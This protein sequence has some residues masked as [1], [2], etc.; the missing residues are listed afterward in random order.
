MLGRFRTTL[1]GLSAALITTSCM[2]KNVA[3]Q[4]EYYT[5]EQVGLCNGLDGK[6]TW[7][8]HKGSVYDI[9]EFIAVHP[10]GQQFIERAAG[11]DVGA[12]WNVWQK[13]YRSPKVIEVLEANRI[14]ALLVKESSSD[15]AATVAQEHPYD[16]EPVRNR[17]VHKVQ[18]EYPFTT[19]TNLLPLSQSY[20][21]PADTLYVRNH[22]PVPYHLTAEEHMLQL[23]D[24]GDEQN[25][26]KGA[27]MRIRMVDLFKK[28][29]NVTITAVMQCAGNRTAEDILASGVAGNGF[30]GTPHEDIGNGMMGNGRWTG[31]RLADVLEDYFPVQCRQQR[32]LG[33]C[34]SSNT[35]GAINADEDAERDLDRWHV[36]FLGA[37]E[38]ESSTP[39]SHVLAA[40]SD[41][42]LVTDMNDGPLSGDHGYPLRVLLPGLAGARSVKWLEEIVLSRAPSD[43]PWN[44]YYYR[45]TKGNHIQSLPLQSVILSPGKGD[46]VTANVPVEGEDLPAAGEQWVDVKGVAYSGGSGRAIRSVQVS[47]DQGKTWQTAVLHTEELQPDDS[48]AFYGWVRYSAKVKIPAPVTNSNSVVEVEPTI[49]LWC[50]AE[51][52]NGEVQPEISPKQRGYLYNGWNKVTVTVRTAPPTS[53]PVAASNSATGVNIHKNSL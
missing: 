33:F 34:S 3:F 45:T 21:T 10:G 19:E 26:I 36:R 6:P 20:L 8:T 11:G 9:T 18:C 46:V 16:H 42:L 27:D 13:H 52:S 28:Y 32:Q 1:G 48:N 2:K 15:S 51:D 29:P 37:D 35:D 38:Y 44:T 22:A 12:F 41:C 31:I 5:P 14:G 40:R 30:A 50:R 7:V 17:S 39:L 43:G 24:P 4:E 47:A 53:V 25:D 23:Q 49:S